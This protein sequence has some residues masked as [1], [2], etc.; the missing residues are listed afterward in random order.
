MN[1]GSA[2]PADAEASVAAGVL[3]MLRSDSQLQDMFGTPARVFD[4]ETRAPVFPFIRLERLRTTD[5][6]A[7]DTPALEHTV[8]FSTASR[9][10]GRLRA[11]IGLGRLRYALETQPIAVSGLHV[12]MQQVTYSDVLRAADRRSFRGVLQ[13]RMITEEAAV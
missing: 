1:A 9:W 7:I 5:A 3:A 12:V 8:T 11:K 13:F 6:G 4:D 2:M 10:G